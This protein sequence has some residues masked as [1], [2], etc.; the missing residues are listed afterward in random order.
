MF[1]ELR[2]KNQQLS[3]T[4]ARSILKNGTYGVLSVQGDDGYPYGVPMNYV[5]GDDAIYF[6]CAKEC[7]KMES[8]QRSDKVSF[9]VVGED[10]VIPEAFSTAYA[11]VIVFGR[12]SVV[13]DEKEKRE[14]LKLLAERF[15]P[16][17]TKEGEAA[18]ESSWNDVC[19]VRLKIEHAAGKA[20]MER[21]KR[22]EA[23]YA[24]FL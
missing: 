5:Y 24:S 6:H 2:R 4:E 23:R 15:S 14:A 17:Y 3:E 10:E 9:C 16:E 8:F 7:H 12:A 22:E 20:G 11:S 18:I 21:I 19:V 1:R 13:T